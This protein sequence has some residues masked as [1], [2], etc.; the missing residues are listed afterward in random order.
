MLKKT[1]SKIISK[2]MKIIL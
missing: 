1:I 2:R